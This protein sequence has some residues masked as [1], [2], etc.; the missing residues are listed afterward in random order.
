MHSEN[1]G[2][3]HDA[4]EAFSKTYT[5]HNPNHRTYEYFLAIA[6]LI[7]VRRFDLRPNKDL[8]ASKHSTTKTR[9]L[10]MTCVDGGFCGYTIARVPSAAS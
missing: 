1:E 8:P 7:E 6:S 9:P 3:C 10:T 4:S 5:S 2:L